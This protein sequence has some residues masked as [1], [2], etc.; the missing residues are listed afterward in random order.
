MKSFGN[1]LLVFVQYWFAQDMYMLFRRILQ[2]KHNPMNQL[3]I[4]LLK[5]MN[6]QLENR[7]LQE[8][9]EFF[10]FNDLKLI[11]IFLFRPHTGIYWLFMIFLMNK[12]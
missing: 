12:L 10:W 2:I 5:K 6:D 8:N 11:Y 9:E 3:K 1:F 7:F 4:K